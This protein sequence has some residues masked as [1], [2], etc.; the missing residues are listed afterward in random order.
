[1]RSRRAADVSVIL[2]QQG[3]DLDTDAETLTAVL[4]ARGWS[5]TVEATRIGRVQRYTAHAGRV[6]NT[7]SPNSFPIIRKTVR[8][9]GPTAQAALAFALAKALEQE[10]EP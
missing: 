1:M 3:F 5:V 10:R 2:A 4:E 7:L 6:R 9:T 8:A